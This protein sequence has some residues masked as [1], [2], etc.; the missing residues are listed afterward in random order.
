MMTILFISNRV[1][2]SPT[3]SGLCSNSIN[4]VVVLDVRINWHTFLIP[5]WL[6]HGDPAP[7]GDQQHRSLSS[8]PLPPHKGVGAGTAS[9]HLPGEGRPSDHP[10]CLRQ[11]QGGGGGAEAVPHPDGILYEL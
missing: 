1:F 10:V 11:L 6:Q 2:A 7:G 5:V 3:F 8:S 9:G 4:S